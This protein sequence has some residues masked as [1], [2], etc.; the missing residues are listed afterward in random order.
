MARTRKK[1]EAAPAV[2]NATPDNDP[3][4]EPVVAKAP[5]GD[6][7]AM[8][9]DRLMPPRQPIEGEQGKTPA[10]EAV[11]VTE[12][13]HA[14]AKEPVAHERAYVADP[15]ARISVSLSD[16]RGGPAIH[17]LR[18]QKFNQVQI[19]FDRE[20]PG[21]QAI[22]MLKDAGWRDRTESEGVWT[23]QI[24]RNARWQSVQQMEREFKSVANAIRQGKGLKPALEG[25]A[26]A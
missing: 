25:L 2:A 7:G 15:Q 8:P 18:S 1:A 14:P 16:H 19:R 6:A 24:D 5:I 20:Q 12:E 4:A 10:A 11:S 23:K 21:E 3:A 9:I 13:P 26:I 17:L 22:A